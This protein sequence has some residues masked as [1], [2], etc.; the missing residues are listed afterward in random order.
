VQVFHQISPDFTYNKTPSNHVL[1]EW[2]HQIQSIFPNDTV[3][4]TSSTTDESRIIIKVSSAQNPGDFYMFDTQKRKL[5]FL[6]KSS[7]WIEPKKM[8]EVQPIKLSVRDGMELFGYLTKPLN[9]NKNLPLVI[10]PHGGPHN[11]RD[12]WEYDPDVQLLAKH[13]YAVLQLNYRGSGGYGRDYQANGYGEWGGKM[14]DDLT[15][16]TNWAINSG[17]ADEKRICVYGASYGGY[18]AMMAAIKEPNLYKCAIGYAGVYDLPLLFQEGDISD[19]KRGLNYLDKV[20]GKDQN[21]LK[22]RSPAYNVDKIKAGLFFV[23]GG[24]DERAPIEQLNAMTKALDN[25][26][27]PY[28]LM[29][30]GNEGHGFY[31]LDNREEFYKRLLSFLKQH[32]GN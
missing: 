19:T 7:P 25:I 28:E 30:K 22:Q 3:S 21:E 20:I 15:D 2:L 13:G 11:V 26:K 9:Q 8:A 31:Q 10:L 4:I 14:Q 23:H 1:G 12:Y 32:I 17:L 29:L 18:A 6:T 5:R 16:A 24:K 27:Y